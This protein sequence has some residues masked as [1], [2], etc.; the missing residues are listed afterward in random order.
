MGQSHIHALGIVP[1]R[2]GSAGIWP[3]IDGKG[4]NVPIL[5]VKEEVAWFRVFFRFKMLEQTL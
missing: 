3:H 5:Y 2:T 4:D 1:A